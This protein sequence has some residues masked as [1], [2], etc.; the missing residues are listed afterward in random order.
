VIHS[1]PMVGPL[2]PRRDASRGCG[3]RRRPPGIERSCEY[4]K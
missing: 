2:S 1:M 4:I 3:W